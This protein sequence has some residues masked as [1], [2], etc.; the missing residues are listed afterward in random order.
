MK[1]AL[2]VIFTVLLSWP[3]L[4]DPTQVPPGMSRYRVT[5]D[6]TGT[7]DMPM[8]IRQLAAM[9]RGRVEL[10]PDSEG[11]FVVIATDAS[12]GVLRSDSRVL[13]VEMLTDHSGWGV[14]ATAAT[15]VWTTGTYAYD[16]AGNISSI[17]RTA[18]A[19]G[20]RFVYDAYGRLTSGMAANEK[21]TYTYD[22][23]GNIRTIARATVTGSV[24]SPITTTTSTIHLGADPENNRL[25]L[26]SVGGQ[27]MNASADYD[28]E[29]RLTAWHTSGGSYTYDALGMITTW[30]GAADGKLRRYIYTPSEE[31]LLTIVVAP[32]GSEASSEWT[33][34]DAG[35]KVLRRLQRSNEQWRWKR[36]Y[37]YLNGSLLA[38]EVETSAKTLHFFNDHLGTPRLITGNGGVQISRHDYLPFGVELTASNQ[39]AECLKFT[40]HERDE[41]DLDYMHARYY[42]PGVGRFLSVD[43]VQGTQALPQSWNKY[44]YTRNSPIQRI[45]PD[46]NADVDFYVLM[47]PAKHNPIYNR[48]WFADRLADQYGGVKGHTLRVS[49]DNK[50]AISNLRESFGRSGGLVGYLGHSEGIRQ[51]GQGYAAAGL[52]PRGNPGEIGITNP[53]LTSMINKGNAAIAVVAACSSSGCFAGGGLD[54]DTTVVAL[55]SPKGLTDAI[56]ITGAL[57][58]FNDVVVKGNGS[59]ADG[60]AAA[61]AV[62]KQYKLKD[63][64]VIVGG[65][66]TRE[67]ARDVQ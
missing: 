45:D 10:Q 65:D 19:I 64:F 9:C 17:G 37:I 39:D 30:S 47:D 57:E 11:T 43:R 46:G 5:I 56:A 49:T 42:S 44:S 66:P 60:V 18:T 52:N 59:V 62:F 16:G 67:L 21:Q 58:A 54:G 32:G 27:A 14:T 40:G 55:R 24:Q 23:F 26:R 34:R 31:R 29:G 38:A 13:R 15:G 3:L 33:L 12:A 1:R 22:R 35:G 8:L 41:S 4:G 7:D 28:G 50:R 6:A 25:S 48:Q 51:T 61:N 20:Q 53:Q 63:Q 36:D 2:L